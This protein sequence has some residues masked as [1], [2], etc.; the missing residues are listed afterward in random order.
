[1]D[2]T[3]LYNQ[4]FMDHVTHPD[5]KYSIADAHFVH[6]G[7]NPSCGDELKLYI[8]LDD[9]GKIDEYEGDPLATVQAFADKILG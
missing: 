4:Q 3:S 7:V 6:D 2:I 9:E 8:K 5:Y 1:M